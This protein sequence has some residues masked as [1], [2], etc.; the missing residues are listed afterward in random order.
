M[1]ITRAGLAW[2]VA[3]L[4]TLLFLVLLKAGPEVVNL[5]NWSVVIAFVVLIADAR[6]EPDPLIA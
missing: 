6:D 5:A 3:L 1:E 4:A 2:L